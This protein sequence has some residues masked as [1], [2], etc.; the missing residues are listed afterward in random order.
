MAISSDSRAAQAVLP[1]K[2]SASQN[3]GMSAV[4]TMGDCLQGFKNGQ[5]D[6]PYNAK[7]IDEGGSAHIYLEAPHGERRA[8][9]Y[10]KKVSSFR[11]SMLAKTSL[12][13]AQVLPITQQCNP[14]SSLSEPL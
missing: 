11:C 7:Q 8:T 1:V 3:T 9:K 14:W 12:L 2:L 5:Y 4:F 13:H 6:M 10:P